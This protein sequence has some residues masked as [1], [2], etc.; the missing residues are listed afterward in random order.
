MSGLNSLTIDIIDIE[1]YQR[2]KQITCEGYILTSNF[3]SSLHLLSDGTFIYCHEGCFCQISSTTYKVLFKHKM[4]DK[5]RGVAITMTLNRR[6]IISD[7]MNN[8]IS[9]FRVE[10]I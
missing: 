3:F 5:F 2:V 1:L 4:K 10:Y 6:Y 9:I 7:N 8:A